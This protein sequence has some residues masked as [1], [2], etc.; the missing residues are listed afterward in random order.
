MLIRYPLS[1]IRYPVIFG[2]SVNRTVIRVTKNPVSAHSCCER[3]LR[4]DESKRGV[5][6]CELQI[7]P[8]AL[9]CS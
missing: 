8:Y 7:A 6:T 3:R 4:S 5:R 2:L 9:P 1:G